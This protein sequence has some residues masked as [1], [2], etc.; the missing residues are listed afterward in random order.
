ME[1]LVKTPLGLERIAAERI[2]ELGEGC[3]VTARPHGYDGLVVVEKCSDKYGL[4]RLIESE[5]LEAEK[6]IVIEELAPARVDAISEAA[7]RIAERKISQDECFAVRTV[8]RGRHEFTSV[9]VNVSAGAL[10]TARVGAPVNLDY[11][12]KIVQIEIVQDIAG[13]GIL[14]GKAEWRKMDKDKKS[15]LPFFSRVSVVQMPYLGPRE[16]ARQIGSRIGRAVQAY[17]VEEL[18]IAPNKAVDADELAVFIQGIG[19]GIESRYQVQR[20]SYTRPARKVKVLVQDLYQLVRERSGEPIIV[21]EPEGVEIRLAVARL[22]EIFSQSG[23]VN[24]LFGSR[25]GIPKGI[26]RRA[27][28]VIDLAPEITLPTE[29]A[30]PAALVEVYTALSMEEHE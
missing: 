10:I 21:F 13:I 7:A 27:D 20:R 2:R 5:V 29:L 1:I 25:E 3:I 15:S 9:D 17:E 12:D 18:V 11:P 4:A 16:G 6:V 23:R 8:R 26:Y 30:A 14:D 28:L 19:E 22:R 24:F